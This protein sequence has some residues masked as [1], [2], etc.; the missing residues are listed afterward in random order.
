M[1]RQSGGIMRKHEVTGNC[2]RVQV[3]VVANI[4]LLM[5]VVLFVV[6]SD[7]RKFC[8]GLVKHGEPSERPAG[9]QATQLSLPKSPATPA[10]TNSEDKAAALHGAL[11]E[12]ATSRG[13]DA[14]YQYWL[15]VGDSWFTHGKSATTTRSYYE[16][17][18]EVTYDLVEHDL[19]EADRLKGL[20]FEGTLHFYSKAERV[21]EIP[22]AGWTAWTSTTG[23]IFTVKIQ[24]WKD[25]WIAYP[26]VPTRESADGSNDRFSKP[27]PEQIPLS[28]T[29]QSPQPAQGGG[30]GQPVSVADVKALAKAGLSDEVILSQIRITQGMY[31]L[32][33]AEIIDLKNSGVSDKVIDFM[34]NTVGQNRSTRPPPPYPPPPPGY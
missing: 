23:S 11:R 6:S 18:K 21:C 13:L 25:G 30:P 19:D 34:I 1:T 4:L 26:A 32:T 7:F 5:L 27:N 3:S 8:S 2:G 33:T 9:E 20:I 10:A 15:Q 17:D 31:H 29:G 16:Q 22:F 12:E 14:F 28:G 24:G